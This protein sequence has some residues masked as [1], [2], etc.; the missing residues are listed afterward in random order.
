MS[1]VSD[2][3]EGNYLVVRIFILDVAHKG[4]GVTVPSLEVLTGD[5]QERRDR[6]TLHDLNVFFCYISRALIL[7]QHVI[8]ALG[9]TPG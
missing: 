6:F 5:R 7:G 3:E 4:F 8:E 2:P 9:F 1:A